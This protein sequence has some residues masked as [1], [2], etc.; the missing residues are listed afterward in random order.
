MGRSTT[1]TIRTSAEEAIVD[2][3]FEQRPYRKNVAAVVLDD[4]GRILTCRRSDF[5]DTW[6]LPQGGMEDGESAEMAL[7]RELQEEIGTADVEILGR[8][9]EIIRYDWPPEVAYKRFRGQEQVYFLCRLTG[10]TKIDFSVCE[11][12][13]FD[14]ADWLGLEAFFQRIDQTANGGFKFRAYQQALTA[15][16]ALFPGVIAR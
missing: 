5:P 11:P 16:D 4:T 12:A 15:L 13:E 14:C 3:P 8:L 1:R 7:R 9:P 6:Q 10:L 2:I